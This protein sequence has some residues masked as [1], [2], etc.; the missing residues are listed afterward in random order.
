[1]I[2]FT[3]VDELIVKIEIIDRDK[4][5]KIKNTENIEYSLDIKC[6]K[7]HKIIKY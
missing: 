3:D 5:I 4:A 7:T 1:M 2:V 6:K